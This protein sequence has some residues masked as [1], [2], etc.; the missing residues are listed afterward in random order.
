LDLHLREK[1]L[2]A[3]FLSFKGRSE[4][5]NASNNLKSLKKG[6]MLSACPALFAGE[7]SICFCV[8]RPF[9]NLRMTNS[10]VSI[11]HLPIVNEQ[12]LKKAGILLER[13][14]RSI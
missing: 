5:V 1:S 12:N 4:E 7:R 6:V 10:E 2:A 14:R 13:K 11:Y 8:S 9:A 3:A